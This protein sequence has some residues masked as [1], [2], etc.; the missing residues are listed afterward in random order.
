MA[1]V[2]R[3]SSATPGKASRGRSPGSLF[4]LPSYIIAQNTGD[5]NNA[6][7]LPVYATTGISAR[8]TGVEGEATLTVLNPFALSASL[9]YTLGKNRS[10]GYP[11]PAIPPL[12][13]LIDLRCR[14][15]TWTIGV[16]SEL[17]SAQDRIDEFETATDG[18]AVFNAY[19][20]TS[21]FTGPIVHNISVML[22]NV[23]DTEYRNH[24]SRVKSIAPEAG[25]NLRL[26]YRL[27]Y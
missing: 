5:I 24:L 15:S 13:G 4:V 9:S 27:T 25:R 14:F 21:I 17:A 19:V 11:L 20:Q 7:L 26:V 2:E 22:D 10:S 1:T 6:T 23:A 18:Y 3:F 8:L 16:S 12:K